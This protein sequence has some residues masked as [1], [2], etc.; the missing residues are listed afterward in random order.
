MQLPVKRITYLG[1]FICIGLIIGYLESLI[2]IPI[3]IPGVKLGISNIV[4]VISLYLFGPVFSLITLLG[5]IFLSNLLFGSASSFI[6]SL[7]GAVI[8]FCGMILLKKCSVFSVYG[9]SISGGVL[10]N[11]A[12]LCT[13]ALIIRLPYIYYYLPILIISGIVAGWFVGFVSNL[14]IKSL[15]RF[16]INT[17]KGDK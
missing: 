5:R 4:T 7:T 1:L 3:G 15:N 12:Q 2:V 8:S 17:N 14:L 16:F 9:V 13:A 11:L 6:Y 10:H